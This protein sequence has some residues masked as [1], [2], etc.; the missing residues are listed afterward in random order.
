MKFEVF[1]G[2]NQQWYWRLVGNNGLSV[3]IGGE[4][5]VHAHDAFN[6]IKLVK[7][8]TILTPVYGPD[9]KLVPGV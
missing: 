1:Q 3:A 4:G 8:T 5:Y 7:S 6:G 2:N 9:G